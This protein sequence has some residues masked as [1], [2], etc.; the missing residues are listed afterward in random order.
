VI[1]QG[2]A[3]AERGRSKTGTGPF[4][5]LGAAPFGTSGSTKRAAARK[6]AHTASSG[7]KG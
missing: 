1:K 2:A 7:G 6:P 4:G 5:N 3:T